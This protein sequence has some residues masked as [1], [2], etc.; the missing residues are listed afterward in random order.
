MR[1]AVKAT[2]VECQESH[3]LCRLAQFW[4][5]ALLVQVGELDAGWRALDAIKTRR[6]APESPR[7]AAASHAVRGK[8]LFAMGGIDDAIAEIEVGLR[9]AERSGVRPLLAPCYT[10]MALGALRRADMRVCF[11]FVDRLAVEALLGYF[12]QAAGAWV[13]A[14]AV[15]SRSGVASAADLVSGI[16]TSPFVLRQL[17]VSEPAAASWL[18][19]ISGKLDAPDLAEMSVAAA[20][21]ASDEH[22]RFRVIRGSALHAA[23]LLEGDSGRL[24]E[25]ADLYPDR[26]CRASAL[27]DMAG[28]LAK[29]Y[30]E[31]DKAIRVLESAR[32][33]YNAVGA[34]RDA[35]RVVSK[36]REFG[37]RRGAVRTVECADILPHGLTKT[38]FAVADLVSQGYSNDE[39][40]RQLFISRHTVAFHL[41]KVF[42]KVNVASRVELA[43]TWKVR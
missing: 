22:P 31:K 26:W 20:F 11:D 38:E 36:L 16:V 30:S 1:N 28:L 32:G 42:Q 21:A 39:V 5:V 27:E 13:T 6:D 33:A 12:G 2:A 34:R 29:R 37:V 9:I 4:Y 14:Q 23:G 7:V 24:R 35:S 40:G 8:L 19:R 10:V 17:L 18:V 15:E 41:K 3:D 43:A 25:A